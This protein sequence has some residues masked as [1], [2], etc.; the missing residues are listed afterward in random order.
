MGTSTPE[1]L[2]LDAVVHEVKDLSVE[3]LRKQVAES[4][5]LLGDQ[6]SLTRFTRLLWRAAFSTTPTSFANCNNC[7]HR[8][9][10][11]D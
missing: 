3:T 2:R 1:S 11:L 5:A 4:R 10:R 6:R 9:S 7:V 8:V